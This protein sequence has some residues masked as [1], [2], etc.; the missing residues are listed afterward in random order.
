VP[1]RVVVITDRRS[2]PSEEIAGHLERVL[3]ASPRGSVAIQIREKD[4]DG[5]PLL[6]LVAEVVEVARPRGAPVWVNDRL[7]VAIAAGCD[8]VH[9]AERG[10]TIADAR[11]A[12]A[13]AASH[14]LRDA[15]TAT[16]APSRPRVA[17]GCSRHWGPDALAAAHDGAALVQLGPIWPT[18]GKGPPLGVEPLAIRA[19]LAAGVQLVAVGGIDS[20]VRARD[21]ALAGADAVAV[22]RAAWQPDSAAR[23]AELVAAVDAAACEPRTR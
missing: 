9:L 16:H 5:G 4:L 3:D 18:P 14:V 20:P 17:I 22:I 1:P 10:L 8:G 23:I 6:R 11:R 2:F 12:I 19:E 21:A 7:D 13:A 15:N